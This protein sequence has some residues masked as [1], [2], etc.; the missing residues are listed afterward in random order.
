M[1]ACVG[2]GAPAYYGPECFECLNRRNPFRDIQV[3]AQDRTRFKDYS[4]VL[5]PN[6]PPP[7]S[8]TDLKRLERERGIQFG[9][10]FTPQEQK[11]KDYARHVKEGGERLPANEINPPEK[12]ESKTILQRMDEKGVRFSR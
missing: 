6:E 10:A 1:T 7:Q 11:L 3:A 9:G 5:G 8:H 4:Q 12:V 2:C